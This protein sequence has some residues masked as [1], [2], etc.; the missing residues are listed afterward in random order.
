MPLSAVAAAGGSWML[1]MPH[2]PLN[3]REW[4]AASP[5][6]SLGQR[7]SAVRQVVMGLTELHNAGVVHGDIK[8]ENVMIAPSTGCVCM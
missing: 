4:L 7:L 6:P 1:E 2:Y 8:P 5:G 3:M